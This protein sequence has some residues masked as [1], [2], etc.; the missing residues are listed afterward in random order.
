MEHV[1][2]LGFIITLIA[3]TIRLSVP[4]L[5][6]ALGGMF[7]ERSGVI[8][9]GLEG[10]MLI[11]ALFGVIG[12][13]MTGSPWFGI[14]FA[15]GGGILL[16]LV[17][18]YMTV[19]LGVDH[20]VTGIALNILSVGL[21]S[22]IFRAKFGITTTPVTVNAFKPLVIPVLKDI[23]VIGPI[24]FQQ[25]ILVY[26][27]FLLVPIASVILYRTSWGLAV[28]TVGEHPKAADTVGINVV[29]IRYI[30]VAISGVLA[31]VAG[32]FLSLGQ[33]NMFVDNMVSGR[34]FIAVAA[35][36]FGK[37]KPL[38]ILAA[39]LVFGLADAL[40]IRLQAAG[41]GIP[42]QWFLMLPYLVTVVA[43]SGLVGKTTAPAALGKVYEKN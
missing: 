5:L 9:I 23:P 14:V 41:T 43:M 29:K 13:Y 19:S 39:S 21:T 16:A 22:F 32:A 33:F 40:Q 11:G 42:Y 2:T 35:V 26:L 15:I 10:M 7:S 8:N 25:N 24:L 18:A 30:C 17:H 38:G 1:F 20:V 28:R 37:W 6:A 3:A 27:A 34:G 12:S 31:G 4:I 36:I